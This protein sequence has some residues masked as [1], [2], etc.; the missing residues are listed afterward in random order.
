MKQIFFLTILSLAILGFGQTE[1]LSLLTIDQIMQGDDFVG[2]L[3]SQIEWAENNQSIYF[4]WNPDRDTIRSTYKADIQTKEIKK[5]S[6]DELKKMQNEG[7]YTKDFAWKVY[8][9]QGDIFLVNLSDQKV[10]QITNTIERE[11]Y[12]RFSG[13]ESSIL[14][15]K[16]NN[17][18]Q[19][20][21]EEGTTT[22]LTDFRKGNKQKEAK[23]DKR[24]AWLEEDQLTHFEILQLRKDEA[25]ARKYRNEQTEVDRP[26]TVYMNSKMMTGLTFSM[27]VKYVVYRLMAPSKDKRTI[28]P[29]YVTESGYTEDINARSKVGG[30]DQRYELWILNLEADS[31]YKVE[32]KD[33]EGIFDKP[34][35]LKE[36]AKDTEDYSGTYEV[37][38]NLF[39]G[40]PLFSEDGKAVVNLVSADRKDRWIMAL[41]LSN[42]KLSLLDRQHDDAWIGGPG[43]GFYSRGGASTLDWIDNDHIWY[44][45]EMTGYSHLYA[46]NVTT[47]KTEALTKGKYEVLS[48]QLSRDK[49]TFYLTTNEKSP[50]EHHFYHMPVS[51]GKRKQI[52]SLKGGHE[53]MVSP[54]EKQ[55]AI[56]YSYA[57]KPW[58]L[59]VMPNTPGASM[60]QLT[61]STSE[62]FNE[63]PWMDPEIIRFTA[64]DGERFLPPCTNPPRKKRTERQLFLYTVQVICKMCTTG[65]PH[66]TVSICSITC[67][68][69]TDTPFWPLTS[70]PVQD[71]A[72]TGGRPYTVIWGAK[73]WMTRWTEQ[74]IW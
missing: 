44:H 33:I 47:G 12:P 67:W 69:I 37:P 3:P 25:D 53:V 40:M 14:F 35:Y 62:E 10:K 26:Y 42:G 16:E 11:S 46:T 30:A 55:L 41:D 15:Q 52:T 49:K 73:I 68:L 50:H 65:G 9:K 72:G 28:V 22:Q 20:S 24:E 38:R 8:Q 31:V 2:Y 19:W 60:V 17:L 51:G 1:N 39:I 66:I 74:L 70:G 27:D 4:S 21:I 45:S 54:D 61:K 6:F 29:N 36:Y 7:D 71:M 18:F 32:T 48:V 57:N 43:V 59:Y 64:K 13:D 23:K 34:E 5:L 56:R 63:Y 58:E